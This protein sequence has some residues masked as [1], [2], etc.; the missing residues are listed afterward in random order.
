MRPVSSGKRGFCLL[1][2][3]DSP[4]KEI[5]KEK[6]RNWKRNDHLSQF[7]GGSQP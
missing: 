7:G 2:E 1:D 5:R 6:N 4:E 3:E